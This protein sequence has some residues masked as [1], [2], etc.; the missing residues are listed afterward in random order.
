MDSSG[1]VLA[2]PQR[3]LRSGI[4]IAF[5][6]FAMLL[7]GA[8]AAASPVRGA[9]PERLKAVIIVGPAGSQTSADLADAEQ[10]AQ[11]AESYGMDVRR[12]FFPHATWDNVM[13]NIQGA[14]LVYYA[15]HGYGWPSPYT[16]VIT[17]SRQD[18]V[19]LNTF[20]GSSAS[21]YTYYGANVLKTNWVLAPNA[22][23]FLN[24]D[25]YTSGNGEPGMA[26]P[27]LDI[28]RQRV[29]NFANGFLAVGA[30]AVFAFEW[31][32]F[33]KALT[34]L[35][36][37]DSTMAQIFETPG[38]KPTGMFGWVGWDPHKFD[39]VRTPG[40]KNYLDPDQPNGFLRAL[41]GD[42]TMTASQWKQGTGGTEPPTVSNLNVQTATG[43]S[44][45]PTTPFFTPNGDGV[46]DTLT[47]TFQV[48]RESFL[49]LTVTN[50]AGD[51]VR[52]LSAWSPGGSGSATW[53]G[54]D[55]GGTY[56]PDGG[57]TVTATPHNRA[58]TDGNTQSVDV[59]VMTTMRAPSVTPNLFYPTDGDSLA[60]STT[61]SVSL[62]AAATF[63]WKI[64]DK[65]GNVV[66]TFVNGVNTSPG[67]QT[68]QWDGRDTN[69][70]FVPDGTYYSVTTT[71]TSAGT[72]FHSLP[73]DVKAFRMT[74]VL[75]PPFVRG[76]KSKFFITSAEPLSAKP[77]L[78]VTFPGL[79]AKT[80]YSYVY[81]GGG[82]YATVNFPATAG[83]G[84]MTI[85][86]TGTDSQA[87]VQQ[88]TYS[89]QLQ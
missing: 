46:T 6:S 32:R 38:A 23:V 9:T 79:T 12:V 31:Q 45:G 11:L 27:T 42:L 17:E 49:N 3:T 15:A 48:D 78:R 87:H 75:N 36:T 39:S 64:A 8:M 14:N 61:L 71:T 40:T 5:L 74:S 73:V 2:T 7:T 1:F 55:A 18:G 81:S 25:C 29:D 13:A 72:Y 10:L 4:V 70:A 16:K 86:V 66:R 62:Q 68:L 59:N 21:Q 30:K 37:T 53:N 67:Q 33:N 24:H 88:T 20:D 22:I 28:A 56:V 54:K 34:M 63:W 26:I 51:V 41:S 80:I 35:F 84:T 19:G 58:G 44:F 83:A 57:Y 60:P 43:P 52:T 89:Y 76:T 47:L 77:R 69:G 50:E 65:N 85:V 82:W